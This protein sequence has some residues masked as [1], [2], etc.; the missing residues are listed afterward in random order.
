MPKN[1]IITLAESCAMKLNM[2]PACHGI[3]EYYSPETIITDRML[4]YNKHCQHEFGEYVQAHT[5]PDPLNS[6]DGRGVDG[7]YL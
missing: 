7:I 3:S 5:E 6:M 4:D 2:F 1:M